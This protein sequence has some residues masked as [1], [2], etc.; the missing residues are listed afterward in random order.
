MGQKRVGVGRAP[1]TK[2]GDMGASSDPDGNSPCDHR[3]AILLLSTLEGT[4]GPLFI[5]YD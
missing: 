2:S 1:G 4:Q 3:Q 5:G